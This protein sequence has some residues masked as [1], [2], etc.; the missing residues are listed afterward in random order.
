LSRGP[1]QLVEEDPEWTIEIVTTELADAN[2]APTAV[3]LSFVIQQ[4]GAHLQML[5]A[6]AQACRYFVATGLLHDA[7]LE[8]DMRQLIRGAEALPK[9]PSLGVVSQHKMCLTTPD[10]LTQ[11]CRDIVTIFNNDRLGVTTD[12]NPAAPAQ[13][14]A[15]PTA[16]AP[17]VAALPVQS[18]Q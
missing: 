15:V 3:A 1:V 4:H 2:G 12:A 8:G 5:E 9:P 7:P 6:L 13:A 10:R 11:V 14:A 17:V 18:R 16:A